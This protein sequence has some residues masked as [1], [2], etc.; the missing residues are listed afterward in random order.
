MCKT[1]GFGY[2]Q[3]AIYPATP[4]INMYKQGG[5]S[6]PPYNIS[7]LNLH[8]WC[9]SFVADVDV[10]ADVSEVH[11]CLVS[12]CWPMAAPTHLPVLVPS[13]DLLLLSYEVCASCVNDLI[14]LILSAPAYMLGQHRQKSQN[15]CRAG[16][17]RIQGWMR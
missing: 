10:S 5:L 12:Q 8:P 17:T 15:G 11:V 2:S 3:L 9:Q 6:E 1:W 13:H 4:G 7:P 16:S 14:I